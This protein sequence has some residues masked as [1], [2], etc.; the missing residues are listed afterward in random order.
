M[1]RTHASRWHPRRAPFNGATARTRWNEY[2]CNRQWFANFTFNG[3]T[4]RTRWNAGSASPRNLRQPAFNGATARTRWNV[5][6]MSDL[7]HHSV[8]SMGPPRER[9]G[10]ADNAVEQAAQD[11]PSMGPPRERGGTINRMRTSSQAIRLQWG[12]RANAVERMAPSTRSARTHAPFN[13]ATA[14]TRWNVSRVDAHVFLVFP[15]MGP[16]RERGGT[17]VPAWSCF[18]SSNLQWGHRANAVERR[19]LLLFLLVPLV[20]SMGPPRER[21]GTARVRDHRRPHDRPSMGPPRERGGT[22]V[23]A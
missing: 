21:G 10:T 2:H 19:E 13:G 11:P 22:L 9:G 23:A 18:R 8:P 16:P 20:P 17:N 4:A 14:R 1:E 12:H 7:F 3:A 6:S 5:N 15:S